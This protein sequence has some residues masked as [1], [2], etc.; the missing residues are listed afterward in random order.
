MRGKKKRT[1]KGLR[2]ES[3]PGHLHPKQILYHLTTKPSSKC[4]C[5][6]VMSSCGVCVKGKRKKEAI[7]VGVEPTI[8]RSGGEC[9]ST[10]PQDH[11]RGGERSQ[12]SGGK[13]G[14]RGRERKKGASPGIEPGPPAP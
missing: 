1:K 11:P 12:S 9:V 3:N 8:F 7:P 6:S 14:E 5:Q 4:V 2:R 13:W 10:A